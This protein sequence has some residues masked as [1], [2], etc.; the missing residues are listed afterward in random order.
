MVVTNK[1]LKFDFCNYG[2]W[3]FIFFF[4]NNYFFVVQDTFQININF[5]I[6][7][8]GTHALYQGRS[9]E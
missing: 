9:H 7:Q 4:I 5:Y 8:I 6:M 1:L 3:Q 2:T